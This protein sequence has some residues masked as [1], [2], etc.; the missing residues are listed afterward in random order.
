MDSVLV[1]KAVFGKET[2]LTYN[3]AHLR[4]TKES[5]TIEYFENEIIFLWWRK[6][7]QVIRKAKSQKPNF[8][9]ENFL[10]ENC[11]GEKFLNEI[12]L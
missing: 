10:G 6:R 5:L 1:G 7:S 3:C 11:F 12:F 8:F 2:R 4:S 9:G